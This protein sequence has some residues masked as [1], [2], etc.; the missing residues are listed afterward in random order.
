[1][2]FKLESATYL[3]KNS[4]F[5]GQKKKLGVLLEGGHL[6]ELV[7]TFAREIRQIQCTCTEF[8]CVQCPRPAGSNALDKHQIQASALIRHISQPKVNANL[9]RDGFKPNHRLTGG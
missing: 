9:F 3:V 7:F 2:C 8:Q 5:C 1:M 6:L 4:V